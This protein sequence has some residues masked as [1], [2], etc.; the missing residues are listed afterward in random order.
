VEPS[1]KMDRDEEHFDKKFADFFDELDE[2]DEM[3]LLDTI[4]SIKTRYIEFNYVDE[5]GIKV[6]QTC[7]DQK[8]GRKVA[9]ASLKNDATDQEKEAFLKEAR[10]TAA[11]QHPNIIPLHDLGLK[12]RHPW[13]TMKF[14][15]GTSLEQV[16][17]SLKSGN[18]NQFEDLSDRLD[19]FIKVCDA[20]AY[21]HSRGVLHLDIKP[22][23]IQ[24]SD[25]G[26][27]LLCDWG[28][29]KVMAAECDEDLLECY[30]FNPKEVGVTIDGLVKGTPG[31]MAPE[32][33]SLVDLKKGVYTDIFSL[34]CVLYKILTLDKPFSGDDVLSIMEKT[35]E[36][37]FPK[38]TDINNTIPLSLE[39]VCL[40]AMATKPEERYLSVIN[41]QRDILNYRNG[42]ATNAE[43]APF[44]KLFSLWCKRNKVLSFALILILLVSIF[45]GWFAINNL[46]LEK[47][48]ALQLA[49]KMS[50]EKEFQVKMGKD[51]APRFLKRAQG[52]YNA[53]NFDDAVNF[54]NSAVELDPSLKEAWK[55]KGLLHVI[56]QEFNSAVI[57][58]EEG[59]GNS[60][61]LQLAKDYS[62]IKNNDQIP[63]SLDQF[64]DL[65]KRVMDN[66]QYH[67]AGGFIHRAAYSEM[68][69]E[70]REKVCMGIIKI[71]NNQKLNDEGKTFNFHY[72][73]IIRRLDVSRNSW[74]GTALILQN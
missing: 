5:G 70:E 18:A 4:A 40:K 52:A 38:P 45:A 71:H 33:T 11:L 47:I 22:D 17:I 42:F 13:F 29:A 74:I 59:K 46:K 60:K 15:S 63:L 69:L 65:F 41:L 20:V 19:M 6:I 62:V 44:I 66:Q 39:A 64:F 49:E 36:G 67:L 55:L 27:V 8:T 3:P 30:T 9:M 23:N 48:N 12:D 53:Y 1:L 54:C 26:D 56:Y 73:P 72:D 16:L 28:L 14:I 7:L 37:I 35:A 50:L 61:L 34:G 68:S 43:N 21:A 51:A 31:Y 57:A 25:Y 10:L 32:Q 2:M 58:L 24:I